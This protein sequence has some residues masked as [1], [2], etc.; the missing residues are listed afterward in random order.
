MSMNKIEG[1]P[2]GWELVRIG[3]PAEGES[4]VVSI[5]EVDVCNSVR[6][7]KN[8]AI[9]RKIEPP[10]PTYVPWTLETCTRGWVRNKVSLSELAVVV[11]S[12]SGVTAGLSYYNFD[13]LLRD[14]EQLDGT[15]CGTIEPS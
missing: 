3:T 10:K 5:G 14:F 13:N 6:F 11:I 8:Y 2:D 9:V 7:A 15:P 12:Q 4:Y 1:I